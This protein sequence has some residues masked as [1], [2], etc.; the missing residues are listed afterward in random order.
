MTLTNGQ[1]PLY[2]C[3]GN[4]SLSGVTVVGGGGTPENG[5]GSEGYFL[6]GEEVAATSFFSTAYDAQYH[7][8]EGIVVPQEAQY[9]P[10]LASFLVDLLEQPHTFVLDATLPHA[11]SN[12]VSLQCDEAV[13][14]ETVI[15]TSTVAYFDN[16]AEVYAID[17][18]IIPGRYKVAVTRTEGS[19]SV[20]LNGGAV[21]VD[22]ADSVGVAMTT[23]VLAVRDGA[24]CHEF[25]ILEPVADVDL[26]ALSEL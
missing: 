19:V 2:A 7:T 10:Q 9:A 8:A 6:D 13:Y 12:L 1:Q 21:I 15:D 16:T 17:P 14:F 20:S 4:Q 18:T 22:E 24:T 25:T 5:F 23:V 26:P 11:L 3:T